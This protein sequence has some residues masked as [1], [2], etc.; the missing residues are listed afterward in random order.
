[1]KTFGTG[2]T[3]S[4]WKWWQKF[5]RNNVKN[6]GVGGVLVGIVPFVVALTGGA[7][8]WL[9][10]A[11]AE[12]FDSL[13]NGT[14]DDDARTKINSSTCTELNALSNEEI[15]KLINS[16]LDGPTGD[17]DENAILKLLNCLSFDRLKDIVNLIGRSN[18]ESEF[19]GSEF[20]KLRFLFAKAGIIEL[21]T[22]DDDATRI[23]VNSLS[24]SEINQ[25]TD[26]EIIALYN[27]MAEGATY[28]DDENAIL[29][30]LYCL[31]CERL[32]EIIKTIGQSNIEGE[33][34][35]VQFDQLRVLFANC[36][37]IGLHTLDDDA[38]RVFINN[39]SC[40]GLNGLSLGNVKALLNNLFEGNTGDSDEKAIIKLINCLSA[41]SV[42]ALLSSPGFS[43]SDFDDEVDGSEWTQLKEVFK[44]K[45]L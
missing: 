26:G 39:S 45:G 9:L 43:K 14:D 36:G 28:D 44:S 35:G 7:L 32:K 1:M 41:S 25:L 30:I 5:Y 2:A 12:L 22:L 23:L 17:D 21:H 20:D 18:I 11:I 8:F 34:D 16:M 38:T 6:K 13:F 19:Q 33:F 4:T 31:S 37:I 10:D 3:E 29:K 27:N 24:C 40:E 15:I 42:Q